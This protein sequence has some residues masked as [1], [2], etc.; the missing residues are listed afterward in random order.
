MPAYAG[1]RGTAA[2]HANGEPRVR[3]FGLVEDDRPQDVIEEEAQFHDWL[4]AAG[5]S[6]EMLKDY[7]HHRNG[8]SLH[9]VL[10][11]AS[12]GIPP[13]EARFFRAAGVE[14]GLV[15]AAGGLAGPATR[16]EDAAAPGVVPLKQ[17][18]DQLLTQTAGPRGH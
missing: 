10:P 12:A 17:A 8:E 7:L 4:R 2:C 14:P 15:A 18:L 9:A 6:P 5:V 3:D 13:L 1:K 11:W 16:L